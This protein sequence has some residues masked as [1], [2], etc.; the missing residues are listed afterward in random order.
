MDPLFLGGLGAAIGAIVLSTVMDGNSFGPLIGPSSVVLVVLGAFGAALMSFRKQ[1]LGRVFAS[2]T[3]ALKG[4]PP[5]TKSTVQELAGMAEIARR[6]GLLA[7]ES[8]L[9]GIQDRF[10]RTG[11]QLVVD[12]A[13]EDGIRSVLEIEMAALDERHQVG[14]GFWKTAGGFAPTFGMMGTVIGLINMLGNLSDPSQLGKGMSVALLTTLYGVFFSNLVFLPIA[15]RL[16]RLNK[17]ELSALD[18]ALDGVLAIQNGIS[19][20]QL[21]ERLEAYMPPETREGY[22]GAGQPAPVEQ[23]A[24]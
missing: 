2:A 5:D 17:Q 4:A 18:V 13:D 19:P 10:V 1:E 6:D 11:L 16:E 3:Q 9:E 23:A 15:G 21:V 22:G 20:R 7:L 24:A 14:I 12:G 8:K